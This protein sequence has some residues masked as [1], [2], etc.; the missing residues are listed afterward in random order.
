M[1]KKQLIKQMEEKNILIWLDNNNIVTEDG[2]EI[3]FYNHRYL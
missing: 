2:K 1:D 3:D